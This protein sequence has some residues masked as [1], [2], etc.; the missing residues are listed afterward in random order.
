ASGSI[1]MVAGGFLLWVALSYGIWRLLVKSLGLRHLK[2]TEEHRGRLST[3]MLL[4]A[5]LLFIPIRGGFGVATINLS[6][7]FFSSNMR[8]NHAAVNPAFSL[9]SSATHQQHFEQ[10]FRFM[11][12][13][14]AS[15]IFARTADKTRSQAADS[16]L[17]TPRPDVYI[18]ILES[19][20]SHLMPSQ[21]GLPVATSLDSIA[22]EGLLFTNAYASSFRTDRAI[23]AILNGFPAQPNT[24]LMK[25]PEKTRH[26]PSLAS[27]LAEAGYTNHYYY[28]GDASF[29][30]KKSYLLNTGYTAITTQD[31]FPTSYRSAK[32]GVTDDKLFE[33]ALSD[34]ISDDGSCP[35]FTV[36]QTLSSHEPFD[37][38]YNDPVYG[39]VPELNAF[40]FTD[41]TLGA[42]IN[43]LHDSDRWGDALIVIVPDHY[44]CYP[45]I[46]DP[47][48]VKMRHHIPIVFTGG[49]LNRFGRIDTPVSQVDIAT[50]LLDAL[51]L[52]KS[53]YDFGRNMLDDE[54]AHFAYCST[55]SYVA[56]VDTA[57]VSSIYNVEFGRFDGSDG[58]AQTDSIL[59]AYVQTLYDRLSEL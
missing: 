33:R 59:G 13:E 27:S 44:G 58:T 1:W 42:F 57:G 11:P 50:T 30:N 51:G 53:R 47:M 55:P 24:S 20:S 36:I 16:L 38:P 26:I 21:G 34:I 40:R 32:W 12:A 22:S 31:D 2:P 28:G 5:A 17:N 56:L 48:D 37:V 43:G 14:D 54:I 3:I 15:V 18:I 19:F 10:M 25:Y 29:A 35:T 4:L 52:D 9:L 6:S 41:K 39:D 7:A 49:A 23:T 45:P 46:E 8:L